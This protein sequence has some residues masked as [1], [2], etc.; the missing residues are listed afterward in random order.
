VFR[1]QFQVVCSQITF[2]DLR[3]K[4]TPVYCC[5]L[6]MFYASFI[7]APSLVCIPFRV[8]S[9]DFCYLQVSRFFG[10][11]VSSI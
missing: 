3:F 11:K 4:H 2:G 1:I 8:L 6:L 7:L 5:K 9:L 10:L